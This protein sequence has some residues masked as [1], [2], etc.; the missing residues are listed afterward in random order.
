MSA[1]RAHELMTKLTTDS[2]FRS[3]VAKAATADEKKVI[4]DAA[5]YGDVTTDD[6]A[7]IA[8][9]YGNELTD[10]ELEAVAGGRTVDWVIAVSTVSIAVA[11]AAVA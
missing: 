10:A 11:T 1:T 3:Q 7:S 6:L 9:E 8:P 5:G 4:I 2:E